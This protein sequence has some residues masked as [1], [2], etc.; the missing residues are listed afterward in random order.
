MPDAPVEQFERRYLD[1]SDIELSE[2]T[3]E[4]ASVRTVQGYAVKFDKPSLDLGG[5][6]EVVSRGAFLKSLKRDIV[7]RW[8]HNTDI[9]LGRMSNQTL[10]LE[11]DETGLRFKL[12]LDTDQ[13]GEYAYRKIQ[14]K[15]VRGMSFGFRIPNNGYE[16]LLDEAKKRI[17]R[18][19]EVD[20][21][22]VS[23]TVFPAYPSSQV[24]ARSLE[25]ILRSAPPLP[26]EKALRNHELERKRLRLI[27]A[28]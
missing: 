8:S 26:E 24:A 9:V 27:E 20:L 19:V 13:W 21:L 25:D 10:E 15:D 11:E 6:R 17:R 1:W 3:R 7:A 4:D 5:F 22:E 14:R 2:E 18:L 12:A 16:W 23:P 28:C